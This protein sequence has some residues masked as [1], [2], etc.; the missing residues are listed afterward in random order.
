MAPG[1]VAA[2]TFDRNIVSNATGNVTSWASVGSV[3]GNAVAGTS[4]LPDRNKTIAGHAE[5]STLGLTTGSY[6]IDQPITLYAL[7]AARQTYNVSG[8]QALVMQHATAS[9]SVRYRVQMVGTGT[10]TEISAD[11]GA[12]VTTPSSKIT[13]PTL[14]ERTWYRIRVVWNGASSSLKV[15]DSLTTGTLTAASGGIA[16]TMDIQGLYVAHWQIIAGTVADSVD[17]EMW[18]YLGRL[19]GELPDYSTT[20]MVSDQAA[21]DY[22]AF[23]AVAYDPAHSTIIAVYRTGTTHLTVDGVLD[24]QTSTDGGATWTAPATI[25]DPGDGLDARDPAITVLSSGRWLLTYHTWDGADIT[26]S[27]LCY[28]MY[29]DDHGSTWSDPVQ[30]TSETSSVGAS[31]GAVIELASGNLIWPAYADPIPTGNDIVVLF[32]STNS[33]AS[34]T[35]DSTVAISG[36]NAHEPQLIELANGT[37]LMLMRSS[38]TIYKATCADP[39]A[40]PL[41]WSAASSAFAGDAAPRGIQ[42]SDGTIVVSTRGASAYYTAT[43]RL[44]HALFTSSDNGATWTG[45]IYPFPHGGSFMYGSPIEI[46][47]ALYVLWFLEH[48]GAKVLWTPL[49]GIV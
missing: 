4:A 19:K 44:A 1:T 48:S 15:E 24:M 46:N 10:G 43:S 33:G 11:S 41:V 5:N 38:G 40:T 21:T 47:G 20:V 23:G 13:G 39:T 2:L 29:S 30:A 45:P 22:R 49:A 17:A 42:R 7:V 37:L 6:T 14:Q 16:G 12:N 28:S 36:R 26:T 25:F 35:A 34:W 27:R 3:T 32:R 9:P 31:A 8:R 18:A